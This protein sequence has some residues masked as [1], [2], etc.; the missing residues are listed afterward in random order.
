M[1]CS[2][3]LTATLS[4]ITAI[5][6][7]RRHPNSKKVFVHLPVSSHK[8]RHTQPRCQ[9]HGGWRLHAAP[10][11]HGQPRREG[12]PQGESCSAPHPPCALEKKVYTRNPI[13]SKNK[14]L[15]SHSHLTPPL[16]SPPPACCC[17]L[18][19]GSSRSWT[20][21]RRRPSCPRG[22]QHK[23]PTNP[24]LSHFSFF[25]PP[26]FF[27]TDTETAPHTTPAFA[28]KHNSST[29]DNAGAAVATPAG[30]GG[31]GAGGA[32]R[33]IPSDAAILADAR[34]VGVL[35]KLRIPSW[36]HSLKAPG[37]WFQPLNLRIQ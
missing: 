31:G 2:H 21:S 10:A 4:Y 5:P 29:S 12:W 17:R 9:Q 15:V 22:A 19:G 13:F 11:A 6:V 32:A 28:L 7:D 34:S 8:A 14:W 27:I 1:E 26:N 35:C 37:F 18:A 16:L 23:P 25:C 33:G 3:C 36:T 20:G 30:G 24:N